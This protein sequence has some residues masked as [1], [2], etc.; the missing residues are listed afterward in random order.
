MALLEQSAEMD[1]IGEPVSQLEH[2]L[3]AAFFAERARASNTEI[4]A[5]LLHDIGHVLPRGHNDSMGGFGTASHEAKGADYL[6]DLGFTDDVTALVGSH[7]DAKRYLTCRN[8]EYKNDLS[9][10]SLATL[11]YQG[12]PMTQQEAVGFENA[13]LFKSKLRVRKWD[14]MAKQES[15]VVPG[16]QHYQPRLIAHLNA[17]LKC[18]S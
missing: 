1:Y 17:S 13:P 14:E 11:H 7:V 2:A 12:G 6:T 16:I 10:A 15:L 18:E 3:Q 4:I 8:Q 5:A 9:E